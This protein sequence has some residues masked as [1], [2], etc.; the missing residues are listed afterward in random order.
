MFNESVNVISFFL[1]FSLGFFGVCCARKWLKLSV[2]P[3]EEKRTNKK[4]AKQKET[5]MLSLTRPMLD[6]FFSYSILSLQCEMNP[7]MFNVQFKMQKPSRDSPFKRLNSWPLF[8]TFCF[9]ASK[10]LYSVFTF[11]IFCRNEK[12]NVK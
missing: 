6:Y 7:S 1:Q 2:C 10:L 8:S 4:K 5:L 3:R 11:T 9:S 12:V